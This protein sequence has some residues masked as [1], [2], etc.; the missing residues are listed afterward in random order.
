MWDLWSTKP[1][2]SRFS[3]STS[4]C[5]SFHRLLHT[6]HH[7]SSGAGTI[8]QIVGDL[9]S[10]LSLTPT[11]ETKQ[12]KKNLKICTR[13]P[14]KKKEKIFTNNAMAQCLVYLSISNYEHGSC[15]SQYATK[16][17]RLLRN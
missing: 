2:W 15:V 16:E 3:P 14:K 12:T 1:H 11:Q 9:P 5:L 6:H 8:G 13:Q 17:T 10:G 7:P 4:A